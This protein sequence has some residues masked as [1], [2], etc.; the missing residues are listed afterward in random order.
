MLSIKARM[1]LDLE[2]T[3]W[4]HA[5]AK[6]SHIRWIFTEPATAYYQRLNHLLDQPQALAYAPMV[7][8]RLQRQR[9]VRRAARTSA[10]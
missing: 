2:A 8:K 6:E 1:T 7:V 3:R 4:K 5:G 9:A 10:V